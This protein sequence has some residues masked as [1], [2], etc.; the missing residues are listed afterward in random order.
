M[1]DVH[2][3]RS[4]SPLVHRMSHTYDGYI[5]FDVVRCQREWR[6]WLDLQYKITIIVPAIV[7]LQ[8]MFRNHNSWGSVQMAH[9]PSH[10]FLRKNYP[11]CFKFLLWNQFYQPYSQMISK[12][13]PVTSC[14]HFLICK[15]WNIIILVNLIFDG[16]V[17]AINYYKVPKVIQKTV[18]PAWYTVISG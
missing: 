18:H 10:I 9:Q 4:L 6:M 17:T 7:W 14:A 2:D 3:S 8:P 13:V 1:V 5:N 11:A 15:L 16:D 12:R